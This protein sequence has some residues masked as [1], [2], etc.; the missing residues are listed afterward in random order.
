MK[1]NKNKTYKITID[2]LMAAKKDIIPVSISSKETINELEDWVKGRALY[3]NK[4]TSNKVIRKP[5]VKDIK[6]DDIDVDD[7]I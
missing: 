4:T 7:I 1:V 6:I 5:T 2:D 3:S